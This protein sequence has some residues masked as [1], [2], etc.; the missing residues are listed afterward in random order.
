MTL[1]MRPYSGEQDYWQLRAMLR[2]VFWRNGRH[3]HSWQ[4]ARLDYWRWHGLRNVDPQPIEGL[5]LLWEAEGRLVAAANA[6][7][8]G[9]ACFQVHPDHRTPALE[10][11]MLAV[12]EERLADATPDG[13]RKLVV[14][15]HQGDGLRCEMLA[16]HGYAP[17]RWPE[18]QRQRSLDLPIPDAPPPEGYVVRALGGPEELPARSWA[19]WRGF[20]PNEPDAKYDGWTWY[21]NVQGAPLYRRDL[22]IVAV[23]P[24]G[25]IASFC[26]LWYDDVTR[27]GYFE[28]VATVPE[29]RWRGLGKAVMCEAMRRVREMGATLVT[30]AGFSVAANAL[31]SS[32]MGSEPE[33]MEGWEK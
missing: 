6:E 26:T 24:L 22:D 31:Y 12:A 23:A 3:E 28:P 7:G 18:Y 15:A 2:E 4:V 32:V 20:H 5:V 17:H 1:T 25:E 27:T 13:Q 10:E 21:R 14:W 8:R 29:H 9:E 30:V 19:S 11:E 16:R 33:V